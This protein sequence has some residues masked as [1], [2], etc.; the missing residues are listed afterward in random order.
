MDY[1]WIISDYQFYTIGF[2][3]DYFQ[4]ANGKCLGLPIMLRVDIQ[5][6]LLK[7]FLFAMTDD[8][9]RISSGLKSSIKH[10]R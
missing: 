7:T 2:K 9:F 1:L 5:P 10:E 3:K 6:S 8:P 4:S